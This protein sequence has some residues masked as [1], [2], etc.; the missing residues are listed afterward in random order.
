MNNFAI[1]N[2]IMPQPGNVS[3]HALTISFTTPQL[4]FESLLAA[5]TPIIDVVF[6]WVVLTGN[7]KTEAINRLSA[8]AISA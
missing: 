2:P 6:V 3:T 7:P 1:R 8:E 5:P 4:T